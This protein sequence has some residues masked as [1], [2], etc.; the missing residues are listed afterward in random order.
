MAETDMT[1]GDCRP[2]LERSIDDELTPEDVEKVRA[3]VAACTD[4]A[5]ALESQQQ[6]SR[7]LQDNLVHYEAPD[8]LKAR[9][10]GALAQAGE[11][12]ERPP[13]MARR[14]RW[15]RLAAAGLLIAVASSGTTLLMSRSAA[16]ERSLANDVL[17]SHIRSLMP[18]HVVD[19]ASNDQHN[20]KPWFNGRLAL[21]PPVPRLD[22]LGFRLVG[23]RLDYLD[24]RAAAVV[25]YARR[26]H[27]INVFAWPQP[28]G[29]AAESSRSSQGYNFVTWRTADTEFWVV[30][31]LNAAELSEFTRLYRRGY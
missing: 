18:G 28:G 26:Q 24:G 12:S 17:T 31:D 8:T 4:C 13:L 5:H 10:R 6:L 29:D 19:V 11:P 22:S 20:V 2:L 27:L 23:G 14:V 25:V 7:L 1:C 15:V 3:H 9:I 30:S 16:K 21:S